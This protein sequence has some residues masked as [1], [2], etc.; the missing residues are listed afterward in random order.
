[1]GWRG[2]LRSLNAASNRALRESQKQTNAINRLNTKI[3]KNYDQALHKAN[4]FEKKVRINPIKTLCLK[5]SEKDGFTS[6]PLRISTEIFKGSL[7]FI[8]DSN[9]NN[10]IEFSPSK[11]STPR[12]IITPLSFVVSQW[13]SVL[14]SRIENFDPTYRLRSQWHKRNNPHNSSI[15]LLDRKN[16]IYY[17]P[18]DSTLSG[19][20]LAKHPKIVLVAFEPFRQITNNIQVNISNV[21]LSSQQQVK[22]T[23]NFD[24]VDASLEKHIQS[25]SARP[26]LVEEVQNVLTNQADLLQTPKSKQSSSSGC[27]III[28][29]SIIGFI[30]LF[31]RG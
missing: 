24:C 25:Y 29:L 20:V 9:E 27:L 6:E 21:K 30:T 18:I 14:A 17:Y 28:I 16:S 31:Y 7:Y 8:Q 5:Y 23:F 4:S 11:Y 2:I 1:M 22:H 26:S 15:C 13:C 19:E 12:F 3:D 10:S